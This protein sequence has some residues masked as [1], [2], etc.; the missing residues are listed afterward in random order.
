MIPYGVF[1]PVVLMLTGALIYMIFYTKKIKHMLNVAELI[2][3][4]YV[5]KY[6]EVSLEDLMEDV[7]NPILP[8]P[9]E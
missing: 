6:G 2:V 7:E 5:H 8:P 1:A 3:G 9:K 4:Y